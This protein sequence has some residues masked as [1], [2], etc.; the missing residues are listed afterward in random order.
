V[1]KEDET[2]TVK[3]NNEVANND[4]ETNKFMSTPIK[5]SINESRDPMT[6]DNDDQADADLLIDFTSIERTL[7]RAKEERR[8]ILKSI[9]ENIRASLKFNMTIGNSPENKT[10]QDT[11]DDNMCI[12]NANNRVSSNDALQDTQAIIRMN[13][14]D[15][16]KEETSETEEGSADENIDPTWKPGETP[17]NGAN[18]KDECKQ[19]PPNKAMQRKAGQR[20]RTNPVETKYKDKQKLMKKKPKTQ[21]NIKNQK[22]IQE[23]NKT[24]RDIGIEEEES[25]TPDTIESST[26]IMPE[27]QLCIE[28]KDVVRWDRKGNVRTHIR[29]SHCPDG[30]ELYLDEKGIKVNAKSI[31]HLSEFPRHVLETHPE[32]Q[33]AKPLNSEKLWLDTE[34]CTWWNSE[35]E[36]TQA[37]EK[38]QAK[39]I[40]DY[41]YATDLNETGVIHLKLLETGVKK[42]ARVFKCSCGTEMKSKSKRNAIQ[43]M[44][45]HVR[46][47]HHKDGTTFYVFLPPSPILG[48]DKAIAGE[49]NPVIAWN[50]KWRELDAEEVP[51]PPRDGNM[52]KKQ[53]KAPLAREIPLDGKTDGHACSLCGR[54]VKNA[55]AA[56]RND[57]KTKFQSHASKCHSLP[58]V[59]EYTDKSRHLMVPA[60]GR[61][62]PNHIYL[63]K[64]ST[65][66]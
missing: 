63:A 12:D 54:I 10:P 21:S 52:D 39:T 16:E 36:W 26:Q 14:I 46:E 15:S 9:Q 7:E 33:W 35:E 23:E 18:P 41:E 8:P 49:R 51:P 5:E 58:V 45:E 55:A 62:M 28:T 56:G 31:N 53:G 60:I 25:T 1:A 37:K 17:N 34:G 38:T 59:L 61:S 66:I 30:N 19:N 6:Q 57:H 43:D 48:P 11:S 24:D 40:V 4:I 27:T 29:C 65:E 47:K 22:Q 32:C 44:K 50:G 42:T 13:K 20:M 2:S 3:F 64:S